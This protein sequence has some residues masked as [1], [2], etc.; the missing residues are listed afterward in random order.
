[1][2]SGVSGLKSLWRL[3]LLAL[4]FFSPATIGS[5]FLSLEILQETHD[6]PGLL[7][8][9]FAPTALN[10]GDRLVLSTNEGKI[11]DSTV[12][13]A[14]NSSLGNRIIH[15]ISVTGGSALLVF[16][17]SSEPLGTIEEKGQQ[18]FLS[19]DISGRT[20][21]QLAKSTGVIDEVGYRQTDSKYANKE[22]GMEADTTSLISK[23][24]SL[25]QYSSNDTNV[26]FPKYNTGEAII[27][28]LIYY[29]SGL[30]NSA[31]VI[32]FNLEVANLVF[33]ETDLDIKLV[34]AGTKQLSGLVRNAPTGDTWE[35]MN[36]EET[37]FENI[38]S[39]RS[40]YEADVVITI[41]SDHSGDF[42]GTASI[43]VFKSRPYRSRY[44]GVVDWHDECALSVFTHEIGHLLGGVHQ[45]SAYD[46]TTIGAF[47]YSHG[48]EKEGVFRTMMVP[49]PSDSPL[50]G[51]FS[52]PNFSCAGYPCG[53]RK[54]ADNRRTFLA[55]RHIIAGFQGDGFPFELVTTEKVEYDDER[56]CTKNSLP[57][58]WEA[59][60]L[61]NSTKYNIE[62]ASVHFVRRDGSEYVK[63]YG[64]G[65]YYVSPA[66]KSWFGW[67]VTSEDASPLY[68]IYVE[69][70]WRYYHPITDEIV[71]VASLKWDENYNGDFSTIR[72]ASTNGG[73][74][75]GH[76]ERF[77]ERGSKQTVNFIA[78][79]GFVLDSFRSSCYGQQ[80]DTT[81]TVDVGPDDCRIEAVFKE[82]PVTA[83]A[84]PNILE[85]R[86]GDGE[87]YL[88]V[89]SPDDGGAEIIAYNATCTDG[90]NDYFG[91][92]DSPLITISG[93]TNGVEYVC[94][95]TVSNSVG[96]S[97]SSSETNPITPEG[98]YSLPIW[99][100]YLLTK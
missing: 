74:V 32:D 16:N 46:G 86:Y 75:E 48:H 53:E 96:T 1:M 19:T 7:S 51:G 22:V 30:T 59:P 4:F 95:A 69:S 91:Y 83:P 72:L 97:P 87:I 9:L 84:R 25:P 64:R 6:T 2:A 77:V 45:Y 18:F 33:A 34:L 41:K 61:R 73:R 38:K 39:D 57:G 29:D 89:S 50:I 3:K 47:S 40:L 36:A 28:V 11:F 8:P 92:S 58:Y 63:T 5:E 78:D 80:N 10:V 88:S 98:F 65:E 55:T 56:E 35:K 90:Y 99:L 49:N 43:G 66:Y 94:T 67:C 85:T 60:A 13:S 12:S 37:P 54:R 26:I 15:A 42:C 70:Y 14:K 44:E 31:A 82:K 52:T 100:M 93:L 20:T 62:L 24:P 23:P 27:S 76:T 68:N 21:V 79:D 71:Q 17:E 81:V